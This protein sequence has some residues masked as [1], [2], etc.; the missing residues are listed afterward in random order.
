MFSLLT[1]I[2]GV[3]FPIVIDVTMNYPEKVYRNYEI[4]RLITA[5][6]SNY[7]VIML[8]SGLLYIQIGCFSEEKLGTA[9]YTVNFL[10]LSLISQILLLIFDCI[11]QQHFN[12][13]SISDGLWTM[14]VIE[15]IK[16]AI[17]TPYLKSRMLL[18]I[19][20]SSIF[21]PITYVPLFWVLNFSWIWS[22]L[23][24]C[25]IGLLYAFELLW[26]LSPSPK[27]LSLLNRT[28]FLPIVNFAWFIKLDEET[29]LIKEDRRNDPRS[30]SI[31]NLQFN[32]KTM[33]NLN[34]DAADHTYQIHNEEVLQNDKP[35]PRA[36]SNKRTTNLN[37]S[38]KSKRKSKSQEEK[39]E[40]N[41]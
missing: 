34:Q 29:P 21:I 5:P 13:P 1:F 39:K 28:I 24:G 38:K 27:C 15:S 8:I 20:I 37:K 25:I 35:K 3:F 2:F 30:S 12:Y 10:I 41:A 26:F 19:P 14:I 31:I 11:I 33:Q 32:V 40:N 7:N 9:R 4:W 22:I 36:S 6:I 18:F 23:T 16:T 17:K